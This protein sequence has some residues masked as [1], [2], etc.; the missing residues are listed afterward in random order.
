VIAPRH[1]ARAVTGAPSPRVPRRAAAPAG[2]VLF[3]AFFA[4]SI[5]LGQFLAAPPAER[6][7]DD[8]AEDRNLDARSC[9][10]SLAVQVVHPGTDDPVTGARVRIEQPDRPA[11]VHTTDDDGRVDAPLLCVGPANLHVTK[12]DHEALD[13]SAEITDSARLDDERPLRIELPELHARHS[14]RVVVVADQPPTTMGS[15]QSLSGAALART[16]GLGLADVLG[17]FSGVSV[18]RTAAGGMGKPIIRG[19]FGRRNLIL[20][21]GIRHEGQDWGIDHAPEIDPNAAGRIRVL[22]GASTTRY[23]SKAIG[24]VVLLDS[25]PLLRAPGVSGGAETFGFS[26]PLG[27]GGALAVD[28]APERAKGFAIR[29]DGN[30]ARHRALLTPTYPLDNSGSWTWNA[31]VRAGY[32]RERFD[33][34][35]S[36]RI[37]RSLLGICRCL[38]VSSGEDFAQAI[39]TSTPIS[40][41]A[42][43]P[44]FAIERAYQSVLHHLATTSTRVDLGKGGELHAR[45][46]FQR[47][48]RDEYEVVR[49]SVT[50]PQYSFLLDTHTVDVDYEHPAAKLGRA[51]SLVGTVGAA[52]QVQRNTFTALTSLIPDYRQAG[53]SVFDV[54]RF[55]HE[56]VEL[57]IGARYEGMHRVATLNERDW[58]GQSAGGRLD[59]DACRESGDGGQCTHVFHAPSVT[60]GALTRPARNVPELTWRLQASSSARIPAIDE[61][62]MNGAAP[63]FP[64][65]G[66]GDSRI[67]VERS[68]GGET[69]LQFD[70]DWLFV[71][72]AVHGSFIDDYIYF[73]PQPQEGQCAPLTCTAR[74]PFP[75]FSFLPTDAAFAGGELRLDLLAPRAPFGLWASGAWVRGFDV[76]SGEQLAFTPAD[77]YTLAGRYFWPDSRVSA[78]GYVEIN[79]VLVAKRR[80]IDPDTDF[81]PAPPAY[82][83]LGA[84]VGVEFPQ[85]HLLHRLSL[86]GTNLTNARYRDYNDLLRYFADQPGWALQLRYSVDFDVATSRRSKARS[87]AASI[88]NSPVGS[89]RRRPTPG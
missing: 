45:Y 37:F 3:P 65:L 58:L 25:K 44:E 12:S 69:T 18:L 31:G 81:A 47:D 79:G 39:A 38:R 11:V 89:R 33:I 74:G 75:V 36:Y 49:S 76:R 42:Y 64:I 60:L 22:K 62:F 82:V 57:E 80:G 53:W 35:A 21:N 63:S 40:V 24:G 51:W 56:R 61:Q 34:E 86:L 6:P 70:G 29:V 72:G 78:R 68:W 83:L 85:E 7:S 77:R 41:D 66:F 67:G 5:A 1:V 46:A 59:Q 9:A 88:T 54:E 20:V 84:A 55:V 17:R 43:S 16:R 15:E 4:S 48:V 73:V 52:A 2:H 30:A 26:N 13:L 32:L 19:Q 23:G 87:A 27:G 10:S 14:R 71:E 8:V 50:G 28:V